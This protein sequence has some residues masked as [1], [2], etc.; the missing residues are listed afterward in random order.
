MSLT[1]RGRPRWTAAV[2]SRPHVAVTASSPGNT[3]MRDSQLVSSSRRRWPPVAD[4]RPLG[5]LSEGN[6]G[7][8]WLA[9]DRAGGERPG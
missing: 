2:D 9:A 5:Q 8:Q 3:A 4:L 7:D 6:E 1:G